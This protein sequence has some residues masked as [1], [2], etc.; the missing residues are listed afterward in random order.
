MAP[1]KEY[2]SSFNYSLYAE[3]G[4]HSAAY[5]YITEHAAEITVWQVNA[6]QRCADELGKGAG[7][8]PTAA[9]P[10]A[11]QRPMVLCCTA[12]GVQLLLGIT[13]RVLLSTTYSYRAGQVPY[14]TRSI[15]MLLP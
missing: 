3:V 4:R 15:H 5:V 2:I 14:C 8:S 7:R 10:T 11:L 13:R 6:R 1:C 9:L 12:A